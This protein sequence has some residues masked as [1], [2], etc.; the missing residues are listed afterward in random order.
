[1]TKIIKST[2]IPILSY[3]MEAFPLKENDYQALD[4]FLDQVKTTNN[5]SE[6]KQWNH[7]ELNPHCESKNKK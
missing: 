1:V 2:L 7:F 4:L 3:A 6:I 5:R